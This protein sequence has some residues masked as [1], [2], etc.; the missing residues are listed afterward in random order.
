[1][2]VDGACISSERSSSFSTAM[3][4]RRC[5]LSTARQATSPKKGGVGRIIGCKSSR[6]PAGGGNNGL[7]ELNRSRK[8]NYNRNW[9]AKHPKNNPPETYRTRP[10]RG[11]L[12]ERPKS[13]TVPVDQVDP[14]APV[15]AGL[16][17]RSDSFSLPKMATPVTPVGQIDTISYPE[18]CPG[19]R[20]F[21]RLP[22]P[23]SSSGDWRFPLL[24]KNQPP[25]SIAAPHVR[26]PI[27]Q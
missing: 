9:N 1:M 4:R 27:S 13:K 18:A 10:V 24:N 23:Q 11:A 14:A 8:A 16:P 17:T 5:A 7:Q 25:I 15:F 22:R 6:D 2:S 26:N 12:P 21:F 3:P 20:A 19:D